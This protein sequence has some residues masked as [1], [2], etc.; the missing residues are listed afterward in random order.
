MTLDPT[1]PRYGTDLMTHALE[2]SHSFFSRVSMLK[3]SASIRIEI[4]LGR[5]PT[6]AGRNSLGRNR[7]NQ[8]T[9]VNDSFGTNGTGTMKRKKS[10]RCNPTLSTSQMKE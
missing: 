4:V 1:L 2:F 6:L 9:F 7:Q 3:N 5:M 10:G 8:D